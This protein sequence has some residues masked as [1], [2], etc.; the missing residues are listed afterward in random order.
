MYS[1]K[2]ILHCSIVKLHEMEVVL[3]F[4]LSGLLLHL[5]SAV[6]RSLFLLITEVGLLDLLTDAV[7][8]GPVLLL[9]AVYVRLFD[10]P[11]Y[12]VSIRKDLAVQDITQPD[13]DSILQQV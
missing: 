3:L 5:G 4:M 11:H 9:L 12:V 8:V 1:W 7:E 10:D 13:E 6:V 2:V